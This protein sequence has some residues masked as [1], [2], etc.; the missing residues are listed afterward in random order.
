MQCLV[1]SSFQ[2]IVKTQTRPLKFLKP[3][4]E[5]ISSPYSNSFLRI[6]ITIS[7]PF[8]LAPSITKDSAIVFKF[9]GEYFRKS[10]TFIMKNQNK[11]TFASAMCRGQ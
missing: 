10:L 8:R 7:S 5:R 2:N 1:N 6:S 9:N 11:K 3:P 4:P